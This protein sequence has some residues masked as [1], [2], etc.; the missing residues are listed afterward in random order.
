[1]K[2]DPKM[3]MSLRLEHGP[4]P[5][6]KQITDNGRENYNRFVYSDIFSSKNLN[7]SQDDRFSQSNSDNPYYKIFNPKFKDET[8]RSRKLREFHNLSTVETSDQ[9][10]SIRNG[11]EA[12]LIKKV[13]SIDPKEKKLHEIYPNLNTEVIK[14]HAK[15]SKAKKFLNSSQDNALL[16]SNNAKNYYSNIFNDPVKF[17]LP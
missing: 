2:N 9:Y 3:L 16:S 5:R 11:E 4:N 6:K 12:Q 13:E 7:R 14:E 15:K 1:M 17:T 10:K 8:A